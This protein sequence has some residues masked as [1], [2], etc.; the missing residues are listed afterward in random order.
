MLHWVRV[1]PTGKSSARAE[2]QA[3]APASAW[4][5]PEMEAE[6]VGQF[7]SHYTH[8]PAAAHGLLLQIQPGWTQGCAAAQ[9]TLWQ[10]SGR[11]QVFSHIRVSATVPNFEKLE[12][13]EEM[14]TPR[15]F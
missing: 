15:T 4:S 8:F 5:Q 14:P 7:K 1:S 13:K 6:P 2:E 9:G 11:A 10:G 3:A 12:P